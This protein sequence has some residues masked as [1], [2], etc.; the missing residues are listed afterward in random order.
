LLSISVCQKKKD[1][2]VEELSNK[3]TNHYDFGLFTLS[4]ISNRLYQQDINSSYNEIHCNYTKSYN[5]R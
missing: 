1:R 2:G 3:N 4:I 5:L